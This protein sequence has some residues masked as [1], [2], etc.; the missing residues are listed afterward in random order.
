VRI[1]LWPE[2]VDVEVQKVGFP[3]IIHVEYPIIVRA[4]DH[5]SPCMASII[6][7]PRTTLEA[8]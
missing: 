5:V 6:A 7:I 2:D 4:L 1:H 8:P 3:N